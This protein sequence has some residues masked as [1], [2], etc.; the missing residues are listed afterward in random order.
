MFF[1]D[2]YNTLNFQV[3]R[4]EN[5]VRSANPYCINFVTRIMPSFSCRMYKATVP[6]HL[7]E[8]QARPFTMSTDINNV[9]DPSGEGY[10]T[11]L[12]MRI[13]LTILFG[14]LIMVLFRAIASDRLAFEG[15]RRRRPLLTVEE[16]V[17]WRPE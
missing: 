7:Q 10:G 4:R 8:R 5:W 9:D 17:R 15:P 11:I 12:A 13:I 2:G 14:G 6:E 3:K 1:G 16:A